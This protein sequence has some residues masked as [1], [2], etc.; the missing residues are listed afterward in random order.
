MSEELKRIW[1]EVAIQNGWLEERVQ[2][3]I[4]VATRKTAR[5]T[6]SETAKK[7]LDFGVPVDQIAVATKLSVEEVMELA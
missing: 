6:A 5:K 4:A 3:E 2:A 7:L 1:N